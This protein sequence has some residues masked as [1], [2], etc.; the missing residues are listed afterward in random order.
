MLRR[1]IVLLA[2]ALALLAV[3]LAALVLADRLPEPLATHW[4]FAGEPDRT[5][6]LATTT[7]IFAAGVAIAWAALLG[8][9]ASRER[10]LRLTAAAW[11]WG[12]AAFLAALH[13]T[14]LGANLDASTWRDARLPAWAAL[15]AVALG[16]AAALVAHALERTRPVA[17]VPAAGDAPRLGLRAGERAVWS[18]RVRARGAAIA[19]ALVAVGSLAAAV[20]TGVWWLAPV[21][22]L[23]GL[24]AGTVSEIAATVDRRGLTIAYGPLGWPRQTVPLDDVASAERTDIDPWRVGGWGI[25]KVP[26]RAG[27]TAI[28]VRGGDGIRIRRMDGRELLVTVPD[29][30]T[31]AALLNELSARG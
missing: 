15:G 31:A 20:V 11:A 22:L 4:S 9:A 6:A 14:L 2:P 29:A 23:V 16:A 18:A 8:Q 3:V 17:R 30:G 24:A 1:R 21:G 19:P 12:V 25:R 26:G 28:V 7:A 5:G 13:V 27:A 10:G